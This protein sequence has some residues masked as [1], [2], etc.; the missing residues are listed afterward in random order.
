M[1]LPEKESLLVIQI[2]AFSH[3]AVNEFVYVFMLVSAVPFFQYHVAI[4]D[5]Q[6]LFFN[7]KLVWAL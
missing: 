2:L 1:V 6:L 5:P 7:F 3:V 4:I